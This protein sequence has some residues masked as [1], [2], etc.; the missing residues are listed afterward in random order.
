MGT[1]CRVNP[2]KRNLK[3]DTY[4][5]D[6]AWVSWI[7]YAICAYFAIVSCIRI[8]YLRMVNTTLFDDYFCFPCK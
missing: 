2:K 7:Q 6:R 1:I 3:N 5:R 8:S 4:T